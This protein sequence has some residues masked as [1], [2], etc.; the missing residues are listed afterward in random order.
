MLLH[1]F[2]EM[3]ESY[4]V[5]NISVIVRVIDLVLLCDAG[6]YERELVGDAHLLLCVYRSAHH[7]RLHREEHRDELG[8]IS[9]NIAYHCGAGL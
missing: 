5:G 6:A 2:H 3:L 7:G 8:S 1:I 4:V 9:L